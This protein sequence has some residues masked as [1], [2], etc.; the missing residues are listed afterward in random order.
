[1]SKSSENFNLRE[2]LLILREKE[3]DEVEIFCCI[4]GQGEY[5]SPDVIPA[6]TSGEC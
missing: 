1:M 5:N 4:A 6:I 3:S 2:K